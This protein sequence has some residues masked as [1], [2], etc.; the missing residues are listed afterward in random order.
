MKRDSESEIKEW[1]Q[2]VRGVIRTTLRALDP[3]YQ[4]EA[5]L[6]I[7]ELAAQLPAFRAAKCV[8]LFVP[9]ASEPD[10]HPLIE[11]A[12]AEG[13]TVLLPRLWK[14]GSAPHLEWHAVKGWSE[15]TEPGPFGLREPDPALCPRIEPAQIDCVF[16]PGMAFDHTGMRL[17]RGGGYYDVFLSNIPESVPRFG[18]MFSLQQV[19][20]LPREPHDQAL[21]A[22]VTEEGVASF[23]S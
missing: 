5:S 18:L 19:D 13:K 15:I 12:W 9:L 2:Q 4:A 21:P 11:E 7:C 20:D 23:S 16:V 8:G 22:I 17:G 6:T 1:K 14:E 3:A 10:V